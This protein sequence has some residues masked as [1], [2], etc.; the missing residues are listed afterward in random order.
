MAS[1]EKYLSGQMQVCELM[2]FVVVLI[3]GGSLGPVYMCLRLAAVYM[4]G[5]AVIVVCFVELWNQ[6]AVRPRPL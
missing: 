5:A 1:Y 2:W 3:H 4:S 6:S